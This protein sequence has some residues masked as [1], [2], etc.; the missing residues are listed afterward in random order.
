MIRGNSLEPIAR[1]ALEKKIGKRFYPAVLVSDSKRLLA[2]LDGIN[3]TL[4]ETL[5]IKCPEKGVESTLWKY[6]LEGKIPSAYRWQI[7]Q[8]L[9]LSGAKVCHY[10]VYDGD[11]GEGILLDIYP[12]LK[13]HRLIIESSAAYFQENKAA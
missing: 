11:T 2:S 3:I 4:D 10:W 9:L 8:G 6:A 5:E 12:D 1:A 13:I 7:Q